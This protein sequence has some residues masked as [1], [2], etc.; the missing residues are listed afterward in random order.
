VYRSPFE[1]AAGTAAEHLSDN[2]FGIGGPA[3]PWSTLQYTSIQPGGK[4][5]YN[6]DSPVTTLG[7]L[8]G[9]PDNYNH[10]TFYTG[11]NATGDNF[12][13]NSTNPPIDIQTY[14][15]DQIGFHADVGFLSV[16]LSTEKNAFEYANL[17]ALGPTP[18][19]FPSSTP[20][21]AALPHFAAGLGA[22]GLLG[23]R[24]KRKSEAVAA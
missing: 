12:T 4:A 1:N 2:G 5:T 13:L 17:F 19:D 8:W 6:F 18:E 15:H 24:R 21:P 3:G 14:G 20:L 9:S 16:V 23:W 11:L 7:F 10:I 22:F